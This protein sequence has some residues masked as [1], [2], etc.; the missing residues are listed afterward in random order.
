MGCFSMQT[1][2][3]PLGMKKDTLKIMQSQ[4]GLLVAS[5]VVLLSQV[6]SFFLVQKSFIESSSFSSIIG[7]A[8]GDKK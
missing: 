2:M 7:R 4:L 3:I 1:Y 5:A 8:Q 6:I